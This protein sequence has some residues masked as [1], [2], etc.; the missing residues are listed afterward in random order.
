MT[1]RESM[2]VL[3]D[4]EKKYPFISWLNYFKIDVPEWWNESLDRTSK[5]TCVFLRYILFLSLAT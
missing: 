5:T 2:Q 4:V 1:N 3:E